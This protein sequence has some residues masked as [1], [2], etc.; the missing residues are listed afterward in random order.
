MGETLASGFAAPLLP[1]NSVLWPGDHI[2]LVL[3]LSIFEVMPALCVNTLCK[4]L[5]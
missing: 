1:V 5:C 4:V 3:E 2:F